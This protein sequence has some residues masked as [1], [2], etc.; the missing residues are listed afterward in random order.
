MTNIWCKIYTNINKYFHSRT[1]II[2]S[3]AYLEN[4]R[5]KNDFLAVQQETMEK[6]ASVNAL[7]TF[8]HICKKKNK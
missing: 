7:L 1:H 5:E 8:I 6:A 2:W 4:Q 3:I